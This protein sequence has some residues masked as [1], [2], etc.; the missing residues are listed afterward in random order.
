MP[1][2]HD[3]HAMALCSDYP[4]VCETCI[5]RFTNLKYTFTM[6]SSDILDNEET[7]TFIDEKVGEEAGFMA[8][9]DPVVSNDAAESTDLARFLA[10]PVRIA[11]FTWNESDAAG[12]IRVY[13]PW[14]LFFD[15]T[16]IKKKL[17]NFAFLQCDL[18][19]KVIINASPFLLWCDDCS[20]STI[21]Q[22]YTNHF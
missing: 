1:G 4:A 21:T 9:M 8:Q 18:R 10:R 12:T 16:R 14:R 7:V 2:E 22:S 20:L 6:Q 17:D 3:Q 5:E 11:N 13:N 15:D 19:V